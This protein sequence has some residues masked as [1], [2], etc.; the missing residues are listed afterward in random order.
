[1]REPDGVPLSMGP[2]SRTD[3]RAARGR[4]STV[5]ACARPGR[6]HSSGVKRSR[7]TV[8]VL[9]GVFKLA[10]AAALSVVGGVSLALPPSVFASKLERIVRAC[11][12]Y[13]GS[14][15]LGALERLSTLGRVREQRLALVV[16]GYAA[17]F[18]V[19][20]V[21]LVLRRHWA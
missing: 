19:E 21:G 14:S 5:A 2:I 8:V 1:M 13:P 17:V 4:A 12:I 11:G 15:L 18:A 3:N 6:R 16:L 10:K 20:G 7:G 9:I